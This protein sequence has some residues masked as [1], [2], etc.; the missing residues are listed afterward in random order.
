MNII[1]L[2]THYYPYT[3]GAEGFAQHIAEYQAANG[4][5]VVV[6]TGRWKSDW[7]PRQTLNGV[8]IVRVPVL[9]I[10]YLQTILATIPLYVA[11]QKIQRQFSVDLIHTHIYPA[12]FVGYLLNVVH[13]IPFVA[14][15]QGGDI[16]DYQEVFGP[17]KKIAKQLISA[18]LSRA[19]KVH[20][21]SK[22][23][24]NAL[25]RM[26]V[27]SKKIIVIPNGVDTKKFRPKNS[28]NKTVSLI[29]TSRLE[30]KNNLEV[31]IQSLASLIRSG[32]DITFTNYGDGS[33]KSRLTKL[34]LTLGVGDRIQLKPF[35]PHAKLPRV[36]SMHDYFIRLST[37]EGF[38]ISFIEAMAAGV[39][40]IG[41]DSG[42]V[43]EIISSPRHGH[44]INLNQDSTPQLARIISR[45]PN[46]TQQQFIR[47][48]V[49]STYDWRSITDRMDVLYEQV[50]KA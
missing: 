18:A 1:H 12:M 34:I 35:L 41:A 4:H 17:F 43:P 11:S 15:I 13:H 44:L 30:N 32:E 49:K 14:T 33:L 21:V 38:G 7:K 16:G 2:I 19:T 25:Q 42:A 8:T 23:L 22:Y 20:T 36:L 24:K 28:K 48:Q 37:H 29:S 3:Y 5:R 45:K 27:D 40:P 46:R 39:V 47:Q 26:G 50:I 31:T 10:R 9:K 6:I